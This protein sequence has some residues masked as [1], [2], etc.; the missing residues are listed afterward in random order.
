MELNP[1]LSL[2]TSTFCPA[3]GPPP[4]PLSSSLHRPFFHAI[5]LS[6]VWIPR[7]ATSCCVRLCCGLG[8]WKG[9]K[10]ARIVVEARLGGGGGAG[11]LDKPGLDQSGSSP[12]PS[13][14]EGGE[15]GRLLQ[16]LRYGGGD[17]YRVLLLDHERHTE[18]QVAAV[19]PKVVPSVTPDEARRCFHDSRE[20]GAGLVTVTVKEHAEFYAQMMARCGLRSFIEPDIDMI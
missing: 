10:R 4:P 12:Q 5:P 6:L 14:E 9:N 8:R 3:S 19:L 1:L 20:T 13:V 11:V 17:R 2:T 7:G 18:A 16:K 15:R